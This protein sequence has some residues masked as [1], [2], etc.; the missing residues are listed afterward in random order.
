[1]KMNL[2]GGAT[3]AL[4]NFDH[5][6]HLVFS[7]LLWTALGDVGRRDEDAGAGQVAARWS[8]YIE[9]DVDGCAERSA[10]LA[11]SRTFQNIDRAVAYA[12]LNVIAARAV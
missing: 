1:M 11:A 6:Y 4:G 2:G 10:R 12:G 8:V 3:S 9:T 5:Y 7:A